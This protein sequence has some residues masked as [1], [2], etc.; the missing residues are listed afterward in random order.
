MKQK[1]TFIFSLEPLG[2]FKFIT[3]P[4]ILALTPA[5]PSQAQGKLVAWWKFD[6]TEGDTVSD[7]SGNN[8]SGTL[9]GDPKWQPD[10]GKVGG[11]LELD[12]ASW[13]DCGSGD[14]LAMTGPFTIA[15]W[16]NPASLSGHHAFAGRNGAYY[17]KSY[18][19]KL[20]FTTPYILDHDTT[21]PVLK[22]GTWQH[23]AV[24]FQPNQ[25]GG[26]VFYID[27]VE[28]DRMDASQLKTGTGPFLIG[29]GQW[30]DHTYFGLIDDLRIYGYPLSQAEVAT[31]YSGKELDGSRSNWIPVLV[32]LIIVAAVGAA[33]RRKKAT[34]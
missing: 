34:A 30:A 22:T 6:E 17:F 9:T 19:A 10:G 15:C 14:V 24:T 11:A 20:R 7:S 29:N 26:A 2:P 23:V 4:Y 27:G 8:H 31:L 5:E 1:G 12:G 28:V 32:I 33:T 18:D 21:N 25:P 13:V 16:V 3:Q